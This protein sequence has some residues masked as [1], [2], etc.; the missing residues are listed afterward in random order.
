MLLLC[1]HSQLKNTIKM[2]YLRKGKQNY[3]LHGK[4]CHLHESHKLLIFGWITLTILSEQDP[5]LWCSKNVIH[6]N[7]AFNAVWPKIP[8]ASLNKIKDKTYRYRQVNTTPLRHM[9]EWRF[10]SMRYSGRSLKFIWI[11]FKHQFRT[12]QETYCIAVTKTDQ[13]IW[14]E[15][16]AAVSQNHIKH[17]E[18][19][20][21][22]NVRVKSRGL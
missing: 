12:S 7:F 2:Y 17:I 6:I 14:S 16:I 11:I 8:T 22:Y 9:G 5:F 1:V 10:N 19:S 21:K 4:Y 15:V 20:L 3:A 13:L 18:R